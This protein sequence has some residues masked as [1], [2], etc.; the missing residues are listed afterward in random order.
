MSRVKKK[1]LTLLEIIVAM[2]IFFV[3]VVVVTSLFIYLY[4][5][6]GGLEARQRVTQE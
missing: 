4:Q 1:A 6:K 2:T 5:I 3:L